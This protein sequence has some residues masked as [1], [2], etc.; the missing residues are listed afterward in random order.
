MFRH[1]FF[2]GRIFG[3]VVDLD[4]SWFFIFGLL[5]WVM[6]VSYYPGEFPHWGAGECWLLGAVT[7]VLLFVSVLLHELGHSVV[8]MHFG[9]PVPRITLFLF[10]GVSQIA[11]EPASAFSEFWLAISGPIVSLLLA[12]LCW[13]LQPAFAGLSPL[14]AL[15]KYLALLN[16]ILAIFNLI[17]GFP[18]D[19]G[20]VLRAILWGSTKNFQKA[21][22]IA[23]VSGQVFGYLLIF[24]G[25]W[26]VLTGNFFNG[27]W[28]AFIGWYLESAAKAQMQHQMLKNLLGG[29]KVSEMMTRDLKPIPAE[30]TLQELVEH[31][32]LTTGRRSFVVSDGNGP[33]GLI[34]LS[35][36]K[37]VPRSAWPT[38]PVKQVMIM[39][40]K[41][42]SI[43]PNTEAWTAL[44]K[45][46]RDGVNQLPVVLN[47]GI[48]GMVSRDDVLHYLR[49]VQAVATK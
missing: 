16:F 19:G 43:R 33:A 3:I 18:L 41:L 34:T 31:H 7:S 25:V 28:I 39:P 27:L 29:H 2:L 49:L 8:A 13:E 12:L 36:V 4:Y 15:A 11:E 23:A 10:G 32:V 6:A 48:V 37:D 5:T 30:M 42:I 9:I 17:P 21:S 40:E 38:T 47:G 46:G 35:A 45:M 20:R 24:G 44:E 1:T 22:T 14:L 26:L